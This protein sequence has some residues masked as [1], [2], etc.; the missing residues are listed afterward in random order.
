MGI[1]RLNTSFND[2]SK[3]FLTRVPGNRRSPWKR[4]IRFGFLFSDKGPFS[5]LFFFLARV[6]HNP[7]RTSITP[8]E[9]EHN[10]R[11]A[12]E[13][14]KMINHEANIFAGNLEA[15]HATRKE[16]DMEILGNSSKTRLQKKTQRVFIKPDRGATEAGDQDERGLGRGRERTDRAFKASHHR[17]FE[18]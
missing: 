6:F 5:C 9:K 15:K 12:G 13:R 8:K 3:A 7:I 10:K 17:T 2:I 16:F 18:L 11:F 4:T 14:L 1:D